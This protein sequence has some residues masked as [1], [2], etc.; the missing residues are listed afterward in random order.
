MKLLN[1]KVFVNKSNGQSAIH[2]PKK[3]FNEIPK[4]V[5]IRIPKSFFK[6]K[7]K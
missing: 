5:E 2:L 1:L 4:N 7:V 6:E 3:L